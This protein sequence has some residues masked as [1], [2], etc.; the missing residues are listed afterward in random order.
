LYRTKGY[1]VEID[2]DGKSGTDAGFL[3]FA[4]QVRDLVQANLRTA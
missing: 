3:A 1:V 4:G 2:V